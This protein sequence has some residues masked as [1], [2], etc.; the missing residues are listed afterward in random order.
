MTFNATLFSIRPAHLLVRSVE[1][2]DALAFELERAYFGKDNELIDRLL[3]PFLESWRT[4]TGNLLQDSFS[5]A[6]VTVAAP[7]HPWGIAILTMNGSSCEP[8]LCDADDTVDDRGEA[9]V[10][11]GLRLLNFEEAIAS[12]A[13]CLRRLPGEE[14][15]RELIYKPAKSRTETVS[16]VVMN[17]EHREALLRLNGQ[18][19]DDE[20]LGL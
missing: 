14:L 7:T 4:V 11:G 15:Q 9:A 13:T 20:G 3:P 16:K 10:Y 17:P 8:L 18:E 12:Y 5:A 1:E 6:G 19:K 2:W